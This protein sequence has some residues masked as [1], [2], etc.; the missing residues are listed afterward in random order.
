MNKQTIRNEY[1]KEKHYKTNAGQASKFDIIVSEIKCS[2]FKKEGTVCDFCFNSRLLDKMQ[3]FSSMERLGFVNHQLTLYSDPLDWLKRMKAFLYDNEDNFE[4]FKYKVFLE[5]QDIVNQ[6]IDQLSEP[7]KSIT[8]KKKTIEFEFIDSDRI[9]ELTEINSKSS[10]DLNG[11]IRLCEEVN[12]CFNE[13][14]YIAV[15][16]LTR[17]I[18]D[19]IPP[20][21]GE[22]NF[23]EVYGHH[24]SK[25]FRE[26][27][28]HLN[29]SM[30]KIA[31]SYLH[32]HVRTE[33]SLPNK[34]HVNYSQGLNVL[35]S[36]I[37]RIIKEK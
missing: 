32:T 16:M 25:S 23:K 6:G 12:L 34:T 21:F 28:N 17:A 33:E 15:I 3:D 22:S 10:F 36:E 4:S 5:Y 2:Q 30:Q 14:C 9:D 7:D 1:F 31:D 18:I 19:H 8:K 29:N 20:I 11:L 26:H 13:E 35:L 27:M 37:I 24:G